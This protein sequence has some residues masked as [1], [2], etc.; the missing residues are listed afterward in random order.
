M[1]ENSHH[2]LI[3]FPSG[4]VTVLLYHGAAHLRAIGVLLDHRVFL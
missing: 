4:W 1:W 3:V 2:I